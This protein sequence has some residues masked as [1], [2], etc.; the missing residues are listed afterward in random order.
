MGK[1][2]IYIQDAGC[3]EVYIVDG[4]HNDLILGIDSISKGQGHIDFPNK[5][6]FWFN[7]TWPLLGEKLSQIIGTLEIPF[8][9]GPPA[10][11]SLLSKFKKIFHKKW[12]PYVR[13]PYNL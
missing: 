5:S 3:L 13:V 9:S 11:T 2:Q 6:F 1:T 8:P 12:T 7:K 10:I 4:L